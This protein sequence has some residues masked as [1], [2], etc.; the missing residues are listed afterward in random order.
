MKIR[1]IVLSFLLGAVVLS[2]GYEYSRAEPKADKPSSKIGVVNIQR[3]FLICKR[4]A[5][6][7]EETKA[8]QNKLN[9]EL[10]KLM[11]ELKAEE[12]GLK[13]LK[14]GSSDRIAQ[15]EEI[16]TKQAG[17]QTKDELYKRR[18]ELRYQLFIEGLYKDILRETTEVAKQK[19]LD[20]VQVKDEIEFPALSVNDAMMAIRTHKLLYSGGCL[21]I[22]DEVIARVDK[23]K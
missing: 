21:D 23:E 7:E 16:L 9:A 10:E 14:P 4:N 6:Y 1:T 15:V 2:M 3:I 19:G 13:T 11:A 20:L 17:L 8:E 22:T 12:A 18:L 5:K